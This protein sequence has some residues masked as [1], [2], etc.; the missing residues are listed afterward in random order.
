MPIDGENK[1][2]HVNVIA[3]VLKGVE[4]RVR[5]VRGRSRRRGG[6]GIHF[7]PFRANVSCTNGRNAAEESFVVFGK[8]G[9]AVGA[10]IGRQGLLIL[11]GGRG[12]PKGI[13]VGVS[14]VTMLGLGSAIVGGT[15]EVVLHGEGR[16]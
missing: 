15:K 4:N 14:E 8:G 11:I 7:L 12:R 5:I 6:Q 3:I 10:A 9:G 1:D 2:G 16:I 13:F